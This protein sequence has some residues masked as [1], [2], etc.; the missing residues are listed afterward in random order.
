MKLIIVF[1]SIL[2]ST[3][4]FSQIPN[5]SFENWKLENTLEIPENW[6]T[7]NALINF[8]SV[9]K[10]E[11]LTDGDYAMKVE[12]KGTSF[13]GYAPGI[14][15]NTF[16]PTTS[17]NTLELSY[18]IDSIEAG[19]N[20]EI[21]VS[22][23]SGNAYL[24]IGYWKG[25]NMS[26]GI[27]SLQLPLIPV[28]GDSIRIEV[29]ANSQLSPLGYVG[30]SEIIVDMMDLSLTLSTINPSSYDDILLY[31][32][33]TNK[34]FTIKGVKKKS[35]YIIYNFEGRLV[36]S[37]LL[38]DNSIEIDNNGVFYLKLQ[39]EDRWVTKKLVVEK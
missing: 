36:K 28:N 7:N 23:Y 34:K 14:A 4:I 37:G 13:E 12:S 27:E 35:P 16:I 29:R 30:H 38:E 5:G 21:V 15:K 2:V 6:S 25:E 33:P 22:Q 3:S 24:Q 1:I 17:F 19:G 26:T 31:P 11:S 10:V 8:V 32:N 9:T 18:K 39:V 20:I